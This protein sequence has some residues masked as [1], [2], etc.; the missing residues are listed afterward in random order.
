[1]RE[2][3]ARTILGLDPDADEEALKKAYRAARLR[4]HPDKGGD[5]GAFVKVSEAHELLSSRLNSSNEQN[6]P[7]NSDDPNSPVGFP[8]HCR[9]IFHAQ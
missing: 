8:A 3:E 4:H 2:D 5:K 1:M 7:G 6:T 9:A